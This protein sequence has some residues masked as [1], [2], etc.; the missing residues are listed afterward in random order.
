MKLIKPK[1]APPLD[2]GF[3]PAVLANHAFR[4]D[5][6]ASGQAVDLVIGLVRSD[7]SVSRFETN[8]F[9]DDHHRAKQAQRYE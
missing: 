1:F 7:D 5:V 3:R 8:I 2:D 9:P 4:R 6:L